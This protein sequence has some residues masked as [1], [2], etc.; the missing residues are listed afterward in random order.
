MF[1]STSCTGTLYSYQTFIHL[2]SNLAT[3]YR[4]IHIASLQQG[5]SPLKDLPTPVSAVRGV[6]SLFLLNGHPSLNMAALHR[7]PGHSTGTITIWQPA[8]GGLP[9]FSASASKYHTRV[10][11]RRKKKPSWQDLIAKCQVFIKTKT[12]AHFH[13]QTYTHFLTLRIC[14]HTSVRSHHITRGEENTAVCLWFI[15]VLFPPLDRPLVLL[16]PRTRTL[17]YKHTHID[18]L[19]HTDSRWPGTPITLSPS[20]KS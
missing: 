6:F 10:K 4:R 14:V 13:S 19:S 5:N 18:T 12:Q 8:S 9:A 1:G 11:T 17:T 20:L 15:F 7:S 2:S 16:H 3:W